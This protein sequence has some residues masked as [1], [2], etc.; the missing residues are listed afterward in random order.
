MVD[1]LKDIGAVKVPE[2]IIKESDPEGQS[3][4]NINTPQD[5]ERYL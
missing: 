5:L 3:F 4:R 1:F 2:S